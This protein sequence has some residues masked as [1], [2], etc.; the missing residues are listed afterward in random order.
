M[1][2]TFL[3]FPLALGLC[4][5][6]LLSCKKDSDS[7]EPTP[8][9]NFSYSPSHIIKVG[10]TVYFSNEST[11]AETY[12]WNFGDGQTSSMKNPTHSY[13]TSGYKTVT[14]IAYSKSGN[15]TAEHTASIYVEPAQGDAMFWTDYT[16]EYVIT[17]TLRGVDK[18]ISSYYYSVPSNCGA[19]GCATYWDLDEG[20]YSY[21]AENYLYWWSGYITVYADECSK[22]LLYADKANRKDA[23]SDTQ[24]IEKLVQGV[25]G[26]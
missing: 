25:D 20:T 19:S 4:V 9:A 26:E 16:T 18:T 6:I 5:F 22:M 14:L 1:K 3:L 17:V 8:I 12:Y 11:N 7:E 2:R 13:R 23:K 21:Y 24:P 10:T 15:K